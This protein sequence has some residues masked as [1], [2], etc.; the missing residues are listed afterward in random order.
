MKISKLWLACAAALALAACG[1]KDAGV[2][3]P[4]S[5]SSAKAS[6]TGTPSPLEERFSLKDAEPFDV[7]ALFALAPE[8][9]RPTYE[10]AEFD[11]KL[12]ATV[13]SNL[14]FADA[15]DGEAVIVERAE[16]YGVD[17][18]A[19]DRIKNASEASPDAPY[20]NVFQ[21][22]RF[23]N[24]KTEGFEDDSG[25]LEIG[26]VEFD[27]LSIRQGGIEGDGEGNEAAR[28]F[29]AV[30]LAGIYFKDIKLITETYDA[31]AVSVTAPD[32]RF[33]GLGGGKLNAIIAKDFS[34]DM[35]Q[36]A[37]SITAMQD[38]MG[39]QYALLMSGPLKGVLAPESQ[40]MTMKS[41][42]WRGIDLSGLMAWGLKGEEPPK[43][44]R[45]LIDLGTMKAVDMETYIEDR[46]AATVGEA[47]VTA[48]NFTWLVPSNIRADTKDATY[49]L[50]AY[51]PETEEASIN[52]LKDYGLDN[53]KGDGYAE[54]VW[55]ANSGAADLEYEAN[56]E[57][58][59]DFS[60][61]LA[62]SGLKLKDIAD[63]E[64]DGEINPVAT[65][66]KF[67][68]FTMSLTDEKALDAL[69]ALSALQMGGTGEDL[70]LSAPAMIRLSGAQFSQMNPRLNGYINAVADFV[71]SGGTLEISATPAEPVPFSALQGAGAAPQDLPD[72]I[73][74]QVTHKE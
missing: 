26:G 68:S 52:V 49:D 31:P 43:S 1:Q 44:E 18:D 13:V 5:E 14:R 45:D 32:L 4:K 11:D 48:A 2:D 64:E 63:A 54:W 37:A 71:G 33:V 67:N 47:T 10:S 29:N 15:N 27:N 30:N 8:D 41:L 60:L 66:G 36:S 38:A 46:L 9:S 25:D 51:V 70:R 42:E 55:N 34:Y 69:F 39:P 16:F 56:T 23:F 7:D 65:L 17:M 53:I 24:V 62:L 19:I 20:E 50:T 35:T 22:V 57:G 6:K 61:G 3:A 59:A 74:L 40:R 58:F 28:F 12:G 21:K 73:D 72:V